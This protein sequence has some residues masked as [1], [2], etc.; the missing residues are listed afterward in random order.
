MKSLR[1]SSGSWNDGNMPPNITLSPEQFKAK[2]AESLMKES[3]EKLAH[4]KSRSPREGSSSRTRG[5]RRSK[6][7]GSSSSKE[8][9]EAV[10]TSVS[11]TTT[12]SSSSTTV[13]TESV[14][15]VEVV[16]VNDEEHKTVEINETVVVE[17]TSEEIIVETEASQLQQSEETKGILHTV[18]YI[19][20]ILSYNHV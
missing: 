1:S 13:V 17:K 4:R 11:T 9:P 7:S 15:H 19:Y 3:A 6:T 8:S 10:V 16:E 14:E 18:Y 20:A 2:S 5:T 12:T